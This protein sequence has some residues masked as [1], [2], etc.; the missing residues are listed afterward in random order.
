M[1]QSPLITLAAG[2]AGAFIGLAAPLI[3]AMTARLGSRRDQQRKLADDILDLFQDGQKLDTLLT[4]A[5]SPPRR[6]L[7]LLGLRLTDERAR[8]ACADLVGAAGN[9]RASEDDLF[10]LWQKAVAEL[11]RVSRGRR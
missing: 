10:P 4:G 5:H 2:A 8:A 1:A 9:P 11:S 7:Y 3:N 6:K